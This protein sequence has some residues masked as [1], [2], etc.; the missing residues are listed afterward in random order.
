MHKLLL[1]IALCLA[2]MCAYAQNQIFPV[3]GRVG[4][5]IDAL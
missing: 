1:G 4:A 3:A 5:Q 2:A